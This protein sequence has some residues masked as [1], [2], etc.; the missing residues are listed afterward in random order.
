MT[1]YNSM[2]ETISLAHGDG[3]ELTHQLISDLFLRYFH[4]EALQPLND[5]AL[6]PFPAGRLALT[7]DSF[8]VKP[9]FFPG[10]NI[11][12]LAVNGTVNDLAVSG[13]R[14]LYL[15]VGLILE[16]GLPISVLE[17]VIVNIATAAREAGI[18]IVTGDTK[19]VEHGHGDLI[20]INTTGIGVV[21]DC[22]NLD[23]RRIRPGDVIICSGSV[24]D[25]GL[26]VIAARENFGLEGLK[27]DCAALHTLILPLL[28][29]FSST[30]KWLRD[31]TRGGLA[32]TM[33]ELAQSAQVNIILSEEAI[34]VHDNVRGGAEILGLDYLYLANEGKFCAVVDKIAVEDVLAFLRRHSLGREAAVIGEIKKG[35]GRVFLRTALGATRELYLL[36]GLQLPRIC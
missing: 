3:G 1:K 4:D 26:A 16:E 25:H 19:V 29:N 20:Y 5:A 36:S 7:T 21:D 11:G 6:L 35:S 34:P 24:G 2:I 17:E 15:T 8:V 33:K 31:P 23:Y 14:P 18:A 28:E 12:T 30:V 9:L 22:I 13:A 27:S 32:T 10:G